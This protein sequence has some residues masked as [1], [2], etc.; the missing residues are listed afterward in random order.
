MLRNYIKIAIRNIL[1]QRVFSFINIL[2]LAI[3]IA[4]CLLITLYLFGSK[5]AMTHIMPIQSGSIVL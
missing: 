2:G 4:T 5:Q 1:R 3:G